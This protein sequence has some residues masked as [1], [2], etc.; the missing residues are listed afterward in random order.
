MEMSNK[1]EQVRNNNRRK[2]PRNFLQNA[3]GH[4]KRG[5]FGSGAQVSQE[6]YNYLINI[7]ETLRNESLDE[8]SLS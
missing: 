6:Q 5:H 3:R 8:E 4:A 1:N 7:M 2:R